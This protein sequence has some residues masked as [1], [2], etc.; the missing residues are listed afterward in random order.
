M[1]KVIF[2]KIIF[3]FM[4]VFVVLTVAACELKDPNQEDE[5]K[6]YIN[7]NAYNETLKNS[8]TSEEAID[9][10]D[11]GITNLREYLNG[12]DIATTGYY[13]GVQF[14]VNTK[15]PETLKGANFYLNIQAHL[16]TYPYLDDD[17]GLIYKYYDKR[18][19]TYYDEQNDANTRIKTSAEDIHNEVIKKSDIVIQWYDGVSNKMLIGLYFDGL[20]SNS[21]DPGNILYV[22]IQGYKRYYEDFGDTVM[23]QQMI[24]LLTSLSVESLLTAGNVQ[25]DAGVGQIRE[26]LGF[27]VDENYKVVLNNPVTSTL[28]YNISAD[29]IA[30][31]I[32]KFYQKLFAPFGD[33]E[34]TAHNID[35]LTKKYLG[36]KFSTMAKAVLNTVNSD[37]QFFTELNNEGTSEIMTG[38]YLTFNGTSSSNN[39]LYDYVSDLSFEYGAYPPEDMK[40]DKDYYKKFENGK[41]ELVGNLY[42]PMLN[43]NYDTLIRTDMHREERGPNSTNNVFSEFRDIANGEL[44]M[45][46]YYRNE[47]SYLDIS[48]MEYLYG[49]I[50]LEELGFPKVYDESL[51]LAE[52]LSSLATWTDKMIVSI[53]DGILSP[54]I[55]DKENQLLE[56][57][58]EKVF[59]T[60][61]D[62]NDIFS[63]NTVT[64]TVDMELI[65][66][67]ME[68]S[69]N[70]TYSTRGIINIIDSISPY[71]MDQIATMLG[72]ASAEVMLDKTYFTFTLN[73]DTNEMTIKMFTDVGVEDDE[74]STMIFQLDLIFN[75]FGE[76]VK[77]AEVNFEGF[78]P[79]GQIYTYSATMDGNFMFS[80]VQTVDLSYLLG[81][82]I[83]DNSGKNTFYQLAPESG[84]TFTLKYD[85][86]VLDTVNDAGEVIHKQGRSSFDL[87]MWVTG[88]D[89][90]VLI[91]LASDDVAFNNEVYDQQP[92][93]EDELGYIWV[94]IQCC[95]EKDGKTQRVPPVKIREDVFMASMQAYMNNTSISDDTSKLGDSDLNMSITTIL[96]ALM[97]DS[98]V[99]AQPEKIEITT[100]NETVQNLFRV[101]SLIGNIKT[102]AGFRERVEG[103]ENI[104][105]T[106]L[107]Y[108]VGNFTDLEFYSPYSEE[109]I[110]H[111]ELGINFYE[112]Y[113][114]IYDPL[115]HDFRLTSDNRLQVY[116][117][118]KYFDPEDGLYYFEDRYIIETKEVDGVQ[119]DV[120]I[121]QRVKVESGIV[122]I[123]RDSIQY[124]SDSTFFKKQGAENQEITKVRFRY[125][126]NLR[127]IISVEDGVYYYYSY[128][129]DEE[130]KRIRVDIDPQ[131]IKF[132]GALN[133]EVYIYWTALREILFYETG[134]QYYFFNDNLAVFNEEEKYVYI[135]SKTTRKF[136]FNYDEESIKITDEAKTQYAPRIDGSLMGEVRRYYLT[137]T[138]PYQVE[139]SL[140]IYMNN[141]NYYND[142]DKDNII[143]HF[144]DNGVKIGDDTIMPIP[145]YVM[146]PAEALPKKEET[147]VDVGNSEEIYSHYVSW[148]ISW[149]D[150]D[151]AE[152]MRGDM[153]LTNVTV[154]PNTMGAIVFPVRIIVSNREIVSNEEG[155]SYS[156]VDIYNQENEIKAE[157]VPIVDNAN[158]DPYD[159]MIAKYKYLQEPINF[160][161]TLYSDDEF[162]KAYLEAERKFVN[163]YFSTYV[164]NI[165]F[166][167]ENSKLRELGVDEKFIK[168]KFTNEKDYNIDENIENGD[169]ETS[170]I[171]EIFN[172]S[173]DKFEDGDNSEKKINPSGGLVYLHTYFRGQLIVLR[174]NVLKRE[175]EK[176]KFSDDD[177]YKPEEENGIVKNGHYVANYYDEASYTVPIHPIFVFKDDSG[178]RYEKIFNFKYISGIDANGNYITSEYGLN[179]A[180][181]IITNI[182]NSGSYYF[183]TELGEIV[184]RPFY[185]GTVKLDEF[186]EEYTE[187][188][189]TANATDIDTADVNLRFTM[190]I[191]R[192]NGQG[193]TEAIQMIKGTDN[194]GW[195][196]NIVLRVRVECPKQ[197]V[198][199][200]GQVEVDQYNKD[201][202][203][204][205][206]T[207]TPTAMQYGSL[208][209]G[210]YQIDPLNAVTKKIPTSWKLYFKDDNGNRVASH[211]FNNIV[212]E[213]VNESN[214]VVEYDFATNTY[215]FILPTEEPLTTRIIAK[216]GSDPNDRFEVVLCIK[217]LSKDPKNIDFYI[218]STSNINNKMTSI[219][220]MAV[221]YGDLAYTDIGDSVEIIENCNYV[222]YTYYVD[223][224]AGFTLPDHL[225]A[226]FGTSE[227]Q[228]EV[229]YVTNW[230]DVSGNNPIY[231]PN[232]LIT[233]QTIIGDAEIQITVYLTIA[234]KNNS[235]NRIDIL[236][237]IQNY[238]VKVGTNSDF[239]YIILGDLYQ[240]DLLSGKELGY[241]YI[242]GEGN[243]HNIVI[244]TG[245]DNDIVNNV[246]V[247]AGKIGLYRD[248]GG[249]K[250]VESQMYPYDFIKELYS[251][252]DIVFNETQ[253]LDRWNIDGFD[254]ESTYVYL[255][256]D[257]SN[258][259]IM[260]LSELNDIEYTYDNSNQINKL[261]M[262][263]KIE[264]VGTNYYL[265]VENKNLIKIYPSSDMREDDCKYIT[266]QA[267]TNHM[268]MMEFAKNIKDMEVEYISSD[269]DGVIVN[270]NYNEGTKLSAI[271]T[272]Q[273]DNYTFY[274]NDGEIVDFENIKLKDF[275][276]I[277][278]Q[279]LL[280]R[281]R[282]LNKYCITQI[283]PT[284][285]VGKTITINNFYGMFS[286]NDVVK[287]VIGEPFVSSNKYKVSLGKNAGSYDIKLKLIFAGGLRNEESRSEVDVNGYNTNGYAQ[288]GE[289][290]FIL[291]QELVASIDT[292]TQDNTMTTN[293]YLYGGSND[294]LNSWYVESSDFVSIIKGTII[295]S[296]PQ[297]IVYSNQD[298]AI[299]LSTRTIEGF[300]IYRVFSFHGVSSTNVSYNSVNSELEI[301]D[302]AIHIDDIYNYYPL[303]NYFANGYNLP[304][305]IEIIT[306]TQHIRVSNVNWQVLESWNDG[307]YGNMYSMTYKGTYDEET[308]TIS[309][310]YIAEADV[311]GWES[312]GADGTITKQDVVNLVLKI[313]MDSAKVIE[314]P[315]QDSNPRLETMRIEE[316]GEDIFV[317]DVDAY[318]D[319]NSSAID[320]NHFVLPN[321]INVKYINNLIH[322]FSDI[323]FSYRNK[324]VEYIPYNI[325]GIDVESL[326]S[327]L[328]L[329]IDSF[330]KDGEINYR[331]IDL[332]VDLGLLQKLKIR[333]RFYDKTIE[334]IMAVI[335]FDD[336]NIRS[337]IKASQSTLSN[338]KIEELLEQFN[339]TRI[340]T[341]VE[342]LVN[343]AR[344]MR[345]RIDI[346]STREI[347]FNVSKTYRIYLWQ[348]INNYYSGNTEVNGNLNS[349]YVGNIIGLNWA[350]FK[351][352]NLTDIEI[353]NY[354]EEIAAD[355]NFVVNATGEVGDTLEE[356]ET[357]ARAKVL[358]AY[359]I[360]GRELL[361]KTTEELTLLGVETDVLN[362]QVDEAKVYLLKKAVFDCIVRSDL[363]ENDYKYEINGQEI[364]VTTNFTSDQFNNFAYDILS[365]YFNNVSNYTSYINVI[366]NNTDDNSRVEE[367]IANFYGSAF[368]DCYE[369]ILN[370]YMGREVVNFTY[371]DLY[372]ETTNNLDLLNYALYY[373]NILESNVNISDIIKLT[374]KIKEL[375]AS[376]IITSEEKE[377]QTKEMFIN[378]VELAISKTLALVNIN[379]EITDIINEAFRVQIGAIDDENDDYNTKDGNTIDY[380]VDNHTIEDKVEMRTSL[381]G[382]IAEC[383]DIFSFDNDI[384]HTL[385]KL[386]N[387]QA[388]AD[389]SSLDN[390]IVAIKSNIL[391]GIGANAAITTL[392][393]RAISSYNNNIYMELNICKEIR[394]A[395]ENIET[396]SKYTMN[397]YGDYCFI[398]SKYIA[399]FN[400]EEGGYSYEFTTSWSNDTLSDNLSYQGN[401]KSELDTFINM[402]MDIYQSN[403]GNSEVINKL[404]EKL[405]T[406]LTNTFGE[407]SWDIYKASHL[408][409]GLILGNIENMASKYYFVVDTT[410]E[411]GATEAEKEIKARAK[412]LY[413]YYLTASE[414]QSDASIMFNVDFK[415]NYYMEKEYVLRAYQENKYT[416]LVG[417]LYLVSLGIGQEIK[418][419]VIVENKELETSEIN[420][421]KEELN[422][423]VLEKEYYE[424]YVI[425]NPFVQTIS[426]LPSYIDVNGEKID[427]VWK[428][429]TISPSG[430]LAIE[431][432]NIYGNIKNVNGQQVKLK[433]TV[434]SWIYTGVNREVAPDE[435]I[436]M[437][438]AGYLNFYFSKYQEYAGDDRYEV[439]FNV[440]ALDDEGETVRTTKKM[441]FYPEDSYLLVN[442][443]DD[444]LM[445][446]VSARKN[447]IMYWDQNIKNEVIDN[448]GS[449][450]GVVAN[451]YL[452]N[453][454]GSYSINKLAD[455][456]STTTVTR[457]KY[458]YEDLSIDKLQLIYV[459]ETNEYYDDVKNYLMAMSGE[460]TVIADPTSYLPDNAGLLLYE[461]NVTY[462]HSQISTRLL[463]NNVGFDSAISRLQNFVKEVYPSTATNEVREKA[464]NI[465]MN[466]N[467]GDS[468]KEALIL[469]AMDYLNPNYITLSDDEKLL[470]RIDACKLLCINQVY[471]YKDKY[472]YLTGGIYGNQMVTV[473]IRIGNNSEI[474]VGS[475]KAK[476]V[477]SD[478]T[479]HELC[480]YNID[481]DTYNE[482]ASVNDTQQ[483][484]TLYIK[485]RKDYWDISDQSSYDKEGAMSPYNTN[486]KYVY[487]LLDIHN[488]PKADDILRDGYRLIKLTNIVYTKYE[489]VIISSSFVI[490]GITYQSNIVQIPIIK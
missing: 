114:P 365:V 220:K 250:I 360:S 23:Y 106:Y 50:A 264:D 482:L 94:N 81:A 207:F 364:D 346:P 6:F 386:Q 393:T 246:M 200:V 47:K 140:V 439:V 21:D 299:V 189:P 363:G 67:A 221:D 127:K 429:V 25:D 380:F 308:D 271:Y 83:G 301:V 361:E 1:N 161:P 411:T 349:I 310:T 381:Q 318:K 18:S 344:L 29:I 353:L 165:N 334:N 190:C 440:D 10:V 408:E 313:S 143:E 261:V 130:G 455:S 339:I 441:L 162:D 378:Q 274:N 403:S 229:E 479:P 208:P 103:L 230:T 98:Y 4:L 235:I 113:M 398:P 333:F 176:I 456:S 457:A 84:V 119:T 157:N 88:M 54:D 66:H 152:R 444:T 234:V 227:V 160:N 172:W 187:I 145:Y 489:D 395:Q 404:D 406:K 156:Y 55:N 473:L 133:N 423:E 297:K 167:A 326:A 68:E 449:S 238:Y 242:D 427:V 341:N 100:S 415:N 254:Y 485:I 451:I 204:H 426:D 391:L 69:G 111:D 401:E 348:A 400:E 212:W 375:A 43:S 42:V 199:D 257:T 389:T 2:K 231:V 383:L 11:N 424:Q 185:I 325:R 78:N 248:A 122:T 317:V 13:M 22:D 226:T 222:S 302:G 147:I 291:G 270:N 41:Y 60:E 458:Y 396:D 347:I 331:S 279:E 216:I 268:I 368:D 267:L 223:T 36:F 373:R 275:K 9:N 370:K 480:Y 34:I 116:Y 316:D 319:V 87:R 463:W 38:A 196:N 432:K 446:D 460:T 79:L 57:I 327:L 26:V 303:K 211:I 486:Y 151:L 3:I 73:V 421:Y 280:Y 45:G 58:M 472:S 135:E 218:G 314:L 445:S 435:Y 387:E 362:A 484:S 173:F 269:I 454:A 407:D 465:L 397:P 359:Y 20:N 148:D 477:F 125:N 49:A 409:D 357:A 340:E 414:L 56:Y 372:R 382:M 142:A 399:D 255:H 394:D 309:Q 471:D 107:M 259:I 228:R 141:T 194:D 262:N 203:G 288:Y 206:E 96:F 420:I 86:Y 168:V 171:K 112:D 224:F 215:E 422:G 385:I 304:K 8:T 443:P 35:P 356:R 321:K 134:T 278:K 27:V 5:A 412:Q 272:R 245:S 150:E 287:N 442:S 186:G 61:K 330:M 93:R 213:N 413:G 244:S 377:A 425:T 123:N 474:Y 128:Q 366:K 260:K 329:S 292:V 468:E 179:W 44:M 205:E 265:K 293:T 17:G 320:G 153:V 175:F 197:E 240:R 490:N 201:T 110:L 332:D 256:D 462:G 285:I 137:I 177:D 108:N 209:I 323:E 120:K 405:E 74:P 388:F 164:F 390:S 198:D 181:T 470:L 343:T 312:V 7:D 478:F 453:K 448:E 464:K 138:S 371:E 247:D 488:T 144:D 294:K 16:Y 284:K 159:F 281:L 225:L 300:R 417:E 115:T 431:N 30:D 419:L 62:P 437:D 40:L 24:R 322:A 48:G 295:T 195:F 253:E 286:V 33:T 91:K 447:Y 475:I 124:S 298:G 392:I 241:Y 237:S 251:L 80:T 296:I 19:N 15:D 483:P 469:L 384:T 418:L 311:L 358:Y 59:S 243:E 139:R 338:N 306:N 336:I 169:E 75:K 433:L 369:Q 350:T 273:L 180:D 193:E 117:E 191:Y 402:W 104:K 355:Y 487:K 129:L 71:S 266:M 258:S 351:L 174:L 136:L 434:N 131:Y 99:V 289:Y 32:T 461:S 305:T 28:F 77:I 263:F 335:D 95:Y 37:L 97:E 12:S 476:V 163:Y 183:D 105:D 342:G 249:Q 64:L 101:K 202:E 184:N 170:N 410:G 192:K 154:A 276:E 282:Y 178:N 63:K 217:V 65:K 85:Q 315:W 46:A 466:T 72:V 416:T 379:S 428:N 459:D 14:N 70:G 51:N 121:P 76:E 277:S 307:A 90:T 155:Y 166:N 239:E 252:I 367:I 109:A 354:I 118:G 352:N 210:Y 31:S 158:V 438:S 374:C 337:Q 52:T 126:D 232:S 89:T 233:L 324:K 452:G 345:E 102:D 290:G 481:D 188:T 39:R 219:E 328:V 214:K 430:N 149:E 236:S 82:T 132:E 436:R 182:G 53:V 146:E 467:M 92:E 450:Q 376:G 283:T